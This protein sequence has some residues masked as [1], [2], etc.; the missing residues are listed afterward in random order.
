MTMPTFHRYAYPTAIKKDE[1]P[2]PFQTRD[3]AAFSELAA[4]LYANGWQYGSLLYAYPDEGP[5]LHRS[6]HAGLLAS[7]DWIALTTRPPLDD[8]RHGDRKW[9]PESKTT[10]E[11]AMFEEF[12]KYL[13]VC[14]RSH[15]RL[16]SSVG[17]GRPAADF[18]FKQHVDARLT[19]VASLDPGLAPA[20]VAPEVYRTIGFFLRTEQMAGHRCGLIA[21]FGM[22]GIETLIWNHIVRTRFPHWVSASRFVVAEFEVVGIPDRPI[23]LD[24][25]RHL[26]VNI[27]V[28]REIGPT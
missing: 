5:D 24:F 14:A 7:E 25:A 2:E 23:T 1:T 15:V 17:A 27:L 16:D 10:L 4:S 6:H 22:G 9:L 8:W 28:E 19:E 26:P 20:R 18:T 13:Q 21:C 12:R 3:G 11:Q